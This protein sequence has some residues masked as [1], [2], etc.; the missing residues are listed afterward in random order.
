MRIVV[1]VVA[2]GLLA[3][4]PL[5]AQQSPHTLPR[6]H[7]AD[8]AR[9][10][11]DRRYWGGQAEMDRLRA[12]TRRDVERQRDQRAPEGLRQPPLPFPPPGPR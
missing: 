6:E 11:I 3:A 4:L 8:A 12:E 7:P 1:P 9:R 2:S 10:D 5:A